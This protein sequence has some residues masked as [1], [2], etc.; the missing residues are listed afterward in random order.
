MVSWE[1]HS[2]KKVFFFVGHKAVHKQFMVTSCQFLL[3]IGVDNYQNLL[4]TYQ[5]LS[6]KHSIGF[7][8]RDKIYGSRVTVYRYGVYSFLFCRQ[9]SGRVKG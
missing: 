9:G 5:K 3:V 1:I 4:N 7:R 2:Y 8:V 6:N